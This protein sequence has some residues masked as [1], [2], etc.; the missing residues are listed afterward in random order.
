MIY[1]SEAIP[2]RIALPQLCCAGALSAP[3]LSALC[4]II[5]IFLLV[6]LAVSTRVL[7]T[8]IL[9]APTPPQA[10]LIHAQLR[11]SFYVYR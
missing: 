1:F 7:P 2:P 8:L 3:A 11:R 9:I 4:P 6:R 5:T 10:E